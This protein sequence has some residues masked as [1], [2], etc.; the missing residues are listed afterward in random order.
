MGSHNHC[1]FDFGNRMDCCGAQAKTKRGTGIR[2]GIP[3]EG[4][5]SW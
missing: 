5:G 2:K 4:Y 3:G 1:Y